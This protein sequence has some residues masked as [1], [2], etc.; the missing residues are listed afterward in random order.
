MILATWQD[1]LFAGAIVAA[2]VGVVA[3]VIGLEQ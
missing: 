1:A 3:F 2:V